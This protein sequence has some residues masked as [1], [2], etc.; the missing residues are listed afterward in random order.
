MDRGPAACGYDPFF[1]HRE[2]PPSM[3]GQLRQLAEQGACCT[4]VGG[5]PGSGPAGPVG[6]GSS[7]G[8]AFRQRRGRRGRAYYRHAAPK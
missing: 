4:E 2:W 3:A 7:E 1:P 8:E 5:P 6:P